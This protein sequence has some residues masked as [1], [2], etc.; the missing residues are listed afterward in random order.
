MNARNGI[1]GAGPVAY[2]CSL[3]SMALVLEEAE[4]LETRWVTVDQI[5]TLDRHPWIDRVIDAAVLRSP[6]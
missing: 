6:R 2:R 5:G 4:L 1:G 3:A